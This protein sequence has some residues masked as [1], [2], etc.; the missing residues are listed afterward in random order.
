MTYPKPSKSFRR[1]CSEDFAVFSPLSYTNGQPFVS[2]A[3]FQ[4]DSTDIFVPTSYV[5]RRDWTGIKTRIDY[6]LRSPYHKDGTSASD[7]GTPDLDNAAGN[8][9]Q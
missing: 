4:A 3:P 2:S 5:A 7:V 1:V 6:Y 9:N 8:N